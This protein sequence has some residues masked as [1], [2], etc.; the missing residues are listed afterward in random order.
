[1][2]FLIFTCLVIA[3]IFIYAYTH[4]RIVE[5]RN[6]KRLDQIRR[7]IEAYNRLHNANYQN[8]IQFIKPNNPPDKPV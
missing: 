7:E 3:G 8:I 1:M 6:H 4:L 5:R 2:G